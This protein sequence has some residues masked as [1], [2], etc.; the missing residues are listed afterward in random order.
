MA[1]NRHRWQQNWR[2]SLHHGRSETQLG[3]LQFAL[4]IAPPR[5]TGGLLR[6]KLLLN[7]PSSSACKSPRRA[8]QQASRTAA[9]S[10]W[11]GTAK[12]TSYASSCE[13]W[14]VQA[15]V[16]LISSTHQPLQF[17]CGFP[18]HPGHPTLGLTGPC[19]LVLESRFC[20]PEED[21]T[22]HSA[23]HGSHSVGDRL[24]QFG[25]CPL[26]PLLSRICF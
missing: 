6:L 11:V 17:R 26:S 14:G 25:G 12:A 22:W 23:S 1:G 9:L 10:L 8:T 4:P 13:H 24:V 21:T 19:P 3:R 16:A 5:P 18:A 20:Q 7:L 2:N 15:S